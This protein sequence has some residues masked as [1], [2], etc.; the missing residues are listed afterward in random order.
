ME[1]AIKL[2]LA[3]TKGELWALRS[4]LDQIPE[5]VQ[6]GKQGRACRTRNSHGKEEQ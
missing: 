5:K 6:C 4:R 3:K 1:L 2:S